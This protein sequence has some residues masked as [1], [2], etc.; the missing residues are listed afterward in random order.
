M[1]TR[2]S[3]TGY[4]RTPGLFSVSQKHDINVVFSVSSNISIAPSVTQLPVVNYHHP[5]KNT[6]QYPFPIYLYQLPQD[7]IQS[8][9]FW[10]VVE[11]RYRSQYL[12]YNAIE[13][14][15]LEGSVFVTKPVSSR[16]DEKS[17][18]AHVYQV[19]VRIG[20]FRARPR[21]H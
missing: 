2:T 13:S 19:I 14:N 17:S 1:K 16:L 6:T 7:H 12:L 21:S 15:G 10:E 20:S 4:R 8:R 11:K 5:W 9:N 18:R 3:Q